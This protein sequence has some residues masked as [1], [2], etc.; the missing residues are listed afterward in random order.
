MHMLAYSASYSRLA[1][2]VFLLA[3]FRGR[4]HELKERLG[5][6]RKIENKNKFVDE[7]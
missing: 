4:W 3:L 6:N 7:G 5:D 1:T 2:S